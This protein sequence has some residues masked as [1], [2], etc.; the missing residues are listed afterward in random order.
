MCGLQHI[1]RT[2]PL[3]SQHVEL[4]LQAPSMH[5]VLRSNR[6]A[7]ACKLQSRPAQPLT[8]QR[9]ESPTLDGPFPEMGLRVAR[10]EAVHTCVS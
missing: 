8:G 3:Y 4:Q 1:L 6:D 10:Q 5:A 2:S 7:E 9:R